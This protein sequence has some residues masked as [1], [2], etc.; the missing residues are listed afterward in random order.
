MFWFLAVTGFFVARR[1]FLRVS[2]EDPPEICGRFK[3]GELADLYDAELAV[4]REETLGYR[5]RG[6]VLELY[7]RH[8]G[9]AFEQ[10][11]EI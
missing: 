3:A 2:L 1:G 4:L 6:A 11:L 5:N 8:A 10:M 9:L 7:R